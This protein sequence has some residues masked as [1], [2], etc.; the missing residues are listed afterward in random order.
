[1]SGSLTAI[2]ERSD[3]PLDLV[4]KVAGWHGQQIRNLNEM[5]RTADV[6]TKIAFIASQYGG[7]EEMSDHLLS[8]C[9][10]LVVEKFGH[11]SLNDLAEAYRSWASEEIKIQG[12]EM[13]GGKFNVRQLGQVLAAYDVRRRRIV[14][15]LSNARHEH[16]RQ[17]AEERR[18]RAMKANF[19]QTFPTTLAN[20]QATAK[21]WED[22]PEYIFHILRNRKLI[23]LT[24]AEGENILNE[25]TQ[26][27]AA[28]IADEKQSARTR[29]AV[30]STVE[31]RAAVIARKIT[32][33]RKVCQ[34]AFVLPE[35]FTTAQTSKL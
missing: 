20:L 35:D 1:M 26:I 13:Y 7:R 27:A 18:R 22:V 5:Q 9:A 28:Q 33:F 4:R 29:F 6:L 30:T 3:A 15:E 32:V 34:E 24:K 11:L 17:Q 8:E 31:D 2:A 16:N 19:E 23:T 21:S 25:S 14:A 12:A 10:F